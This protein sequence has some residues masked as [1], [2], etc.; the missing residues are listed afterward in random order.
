[1][2]KKETEIEGTWIEW[3]CGMASWKGNQPIQRM[4]WLEL[5]SGTIFFFNK[6]IHVF[7]RHFVQDM[8]DEASW[9]GHHLI[10]YDLQG[11]QERKRT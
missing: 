8:I 5:I 2:K 1:M 3:Q 4:G 6:K 7:H 11:K 10:E 9:L